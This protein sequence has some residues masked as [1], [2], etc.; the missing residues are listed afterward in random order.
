MAYDNHEIPR[1][2][3]FKTT[4]FTNVFQALVDTYGVPSYLEANPVPITIVT[5][6]FFF[7]MMFGDL[8]HGSL[9][10]LLGGIMVL[11]NN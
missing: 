2:T 8:G 3:Y 9:Y 7:G 6:P 11:F 10:L 4:D 5:F 1:P